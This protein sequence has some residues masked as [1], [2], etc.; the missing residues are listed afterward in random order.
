M[1]KIAITILAAVLMLTAQAQKVTFNSPGI[2]AG[3]RHHLG[4]DANADI[5]QSRTDTITAIDLSGLGITDLRDIVYLPNVRTLDL[6]GNEITNVGPLNVL[7]SLCELNLKKNA[8]ESIN[9]LAFSNAD[10]MMV[11]VT[12]NYIEDFSYLFDCIKCQFTLIGMNRQQKKDIPYLDVYQLYADVKDN[13]QPVIW[14]RGFTN[15][16][17]TPVMVC[18]D[19]RA[20]ATI[21]GHLNSIAIPGTPTGTT[22]VV[23]SCGALSDTTY[24]VPPAN[25]VVKAGETIT[26]ETGLPDDYCVLYA[27]ANYGNVEIDGNA[28]RY[29]T[30]NDV[31]DTIHFCYCLG[32]TL[33]G[34]SRFYLNMVLLG[35]VNMDGMTDISDVVA[36]VSYILGSEPSVFN[37]TAAD[38]NKDS[39]IDISDLVRILNL[40]LGQ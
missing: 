22:A 2:E 5:P 38:L 7:D 35:D 11:D 36:M 4:L 37:R 14:Y 40:I 13:G 12:A 33:K 3:V 10:K 27:Y 15:M 23:L 17:E 24:I 39:R 32:E 6:S 1:R 28:I 16:Q 19:A 20:D 26:I 31:E 18:G 29:T 8:L 9:L 21:D 30:D 25:F 34:F